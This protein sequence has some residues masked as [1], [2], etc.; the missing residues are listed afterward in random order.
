M[1][2]FSLSVTHNVMIWDCMSGSI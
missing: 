1:R 2:Y